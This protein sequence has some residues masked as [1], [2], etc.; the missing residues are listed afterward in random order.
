MPPI[1]TITREGQIEPFV[2]EK[3][4]KKNQFKHWILRWQAQWNQ[5][6]PEQVQFLREKGALKKALHHQCA[7]ASSLMRNLW[8]QGMEYAE[9]VDEAEKQFLAMPTRREEQRLTKE[10][11]PFGQPAKYQL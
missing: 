9:A 1:E 2:T 7:Q 3:D 5:A 11:A 4:V 8:D 6:R 10:L